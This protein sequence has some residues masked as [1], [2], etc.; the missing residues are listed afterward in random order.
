NAP[1][2]ALPSAPYG[3]Y[4][5]RTYARYLGLEEAALVELFDGRDGLAA[6]PRVEALM[7][8]LPPAPKRYRWTFRFLLAASLA[9]LLAMAA[10]RLTSGSRPPAHLLLQRSPQAAAP[11]SAPSRS[12]AL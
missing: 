8:R 11:S 4:F 10:L 6:E 1:R 9:S 12:S 7:E 3:R 2:E 5:L